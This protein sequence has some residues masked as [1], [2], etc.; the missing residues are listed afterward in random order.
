MWCV[1]VYVKEEERQRQRH[2]QS[3]TAPV[4]SHKTDLS[5]ALPFL[6]SLCVNTAVQMER[7]KSGSQ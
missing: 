4:W 2:G 3:A 1:Y 7:W 5:F 6:F